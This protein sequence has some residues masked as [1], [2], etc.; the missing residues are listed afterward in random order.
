MNTYRSLKAIQS[1][2]QANDITCLSL[3]QSYL[4][5]IY[6]K[7]D[8]NIFLEVYEDDALALAQA[9][10]KK[11]KT[12][13]AGRL[14]GMII[15]I[16]DNICYEG[17]R[18]SA[19]SKILDGFESM[20]SATVVERLLAEDAIII[21]RTNCDEFAM[22]STNENSAFGP[23]LNPINTK[24]VSGGSSG[25]SAAA[26]AADLC[27][28]SLGSDTGG[29]IR[30]PASFCGVMGYKPTYGRV[31][32]WGLIAY[33]S[34]FDQIGPF[35]HNVEDAALLMEVIAGSDEYDS[36]C[37]E[38]IVPKYSQKLNNNKS[39]TI[40]Y[41]KETL[42][43][44]ALDAQVKSHIIDKI[45]Q[46]KASG[47]K[48]IAID[49]PY[50]QY[51][52][53]TY[54]VLTTAEA[55][56]NLARYDGVHFGYRSA[57]AQDIPSTYANSRTQGFG[58]E[59]QR[60]IMLGTF[61]LSAGYYD[62]YY[63]KAQ[64]VRRLLLNKTHAIFEKCDFILSPTSPHTALEIGKT[65]DDPTKLY[66]EDI[67]TVHANIVGIPAVSLPTGTHSNGMPFGI[68]LMAPAFNDDELL[69]ISNQIMNI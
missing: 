13:T 7:Q 15:G 48:V 41:I 8:L 51:L 2:L 30:Q 37:S 12:G 3:T 69:T 9:V 5:R 14:A 4:N 28:A 39:Y 46:L 32:R 45:E 60:R 24:C 67:F 61:V 49:F 18:L 40:G 53:P 58:E 52:V 21:G 23:V 38:K 34:S 1:A 26:V 42:E 35:T 33:A 36:T 22:G 19:A 11:L 25:G 43:S 6:E 68:Q 50:L 64:K 65:Y 47:H 63:T 29:S 17:Y 16:K 10:D 31:S 27:L 56:S 44:S 54:Y 57:D 59:V 62:A 66:L 20:F 55:S